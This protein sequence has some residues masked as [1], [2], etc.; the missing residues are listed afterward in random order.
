MA[1]IIDQIRHSIHEFFIFGVILFCYKLGQ[2][3]YKDEYQNNSKNNSI[4]LVIFTYLG[5]LIPCIAISMAISGGVPMRCGNY[6][7]PN[8]GDC[9]QEYE[10]SE[11]YKNHSWDKYP[12]YYSLLTITPYSFG[13][14]N[15][16]KNRIN[17]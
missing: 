6:A 17:L 10:Y 8:S 4:F 1:E 5:N 15:K 2:Y 13:F 16:R 14:L 11:F 9:D 3:A 7:D 12:L